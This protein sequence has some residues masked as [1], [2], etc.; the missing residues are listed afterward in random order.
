MDYY[1]RSYI[2]HMIREECKDRE[3]ALL[4]ALRGGQIRSTVE[5]KNLLE[6]INWDRRKL[7]LYMNISRLKEIP[8]FTFNIRD[9]SKETHDWFLTGF[10][11]M[12]YETD[13]FFD[14]DKSLEDSWEALIEDVRK[15]KEFLE[16]FEVPY[17]LFFSG[18]KG[19]QIVVDGKYMPQRDYL[20]EVSELHK[21]IVE[22][23]K[24]ALDLKFL[25]LANNGLVQRL[26]KVP[27][28]LV[29]PKDIEKSNTQAMYNEQ[30]LKVVLPLTD[31]QF[32]SFKVEDMM[33]VNVMK[34]VQMFKRGNL[35]RYSELSIETKKKNVLKFIKECTF[36]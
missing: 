12:V 5:L 30:L 7:N 35:E 6:L 23:V 15:L 17:Q 1:L 33:L 31:L 16:S 34:K 13:L 29:L 36:S 20:S 18:N 19:F 32:N 9:R 22:N 28:S 2:M 21:Q 4:P 24:I 3:V 25:D 10:N 26:R 8:N 27:Y 14:F 11:Q